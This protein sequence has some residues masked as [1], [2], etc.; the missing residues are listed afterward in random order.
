[1]WGCEDVKMRR[2]EDVRMWRCEDARMRRCEDLKMRRCENVWQAPTI[3]RTLRS[4]ALGKNMEKQ[5]KTQG[6]AT[7]LPFCAPASSFFWLCLFSDLLS[8]SL[9]FSSLLWLF[10]PLLFHLSILSEVWLLNFLR[11]YDIWYVGKS[12]NMAMAYT[13][14]AFLRANLNC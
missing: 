7:F 4:D 14:K 6:F 11:W 3:R 10:P 13:N 2:C 12:G 1:M 5:W 8:S 9:L